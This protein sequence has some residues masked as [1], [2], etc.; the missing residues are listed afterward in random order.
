M[1]KYGITYRRLRPALNDDMNE[2]D[3][4]SRFARRQ[5]S[6]SSFSVPFLGRQESGDLQRSGQDVRVCIS[7]L[8]RLLY[9]RLARQ[10]ALSS[11][12]VVRRGIGR[13]RFFLSLYGRD[14]RL[15]FTNSIARVSPNLSSRFFMYNRTFVGRLP[16]SI[17]GCSLHSYL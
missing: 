2:C 5:A 6:V 13:S 4:A 7:C 11:A 16:T 10:C 15:L 8:A 12:H 1:F 9:H 17:V 3:L 14:V